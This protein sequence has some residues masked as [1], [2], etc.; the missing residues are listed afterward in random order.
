MTAIKK[1]AGFE[2]DHKFYHLPRGAVDPCDKLLL[3]TPNGKW[4]YDDFDA[5]VENNTE[6]KHQTAYQCLKFLGELN[7]IVV[8]DA[9]TVAVLH[10]KR[11]VSHP[12][13]EL[14]A[15]Q[16]PQFEV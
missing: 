11:T 3:S 7:K 12:L 1:L 10:P 14:A 15:F 6:G 5:V 4:Y 13:F 8:Q 9:A 16:S 2:G